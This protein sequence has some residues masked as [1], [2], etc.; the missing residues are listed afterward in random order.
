MAVSRIGSVT[1]VACGYGEGLSLSLRTK[2]RC[3][4]ED[5]ARCAADAASLPGALRLILCGS[6]TAA[7]WPAPAG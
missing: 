6:L 1:R 4:V 2:A 5:E 7:S 3:K